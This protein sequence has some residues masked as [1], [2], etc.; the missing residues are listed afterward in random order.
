[1]LRLES[2]PH[3]YKLKTEISAFKMNSRQ[4]KKTIQDL[5][6]LVK[7]LKSE[8]SKLR[9]YKGKPE[10]R[11]DPNIEAK[12]KIFQGKISDLESNNDTLKG[13]LTKI[14]RYMK[15]AGIDLD[16]LKHA[17]ETGELR[18][19]NSKIKIVSDKCNCKSKV[20]SCQPNDTP[21]QLKQFKLK[22]IS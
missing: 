2:D 6:D 22:S 14:M 18:C 9:F 20:C 17:V 21:K 1:M 4:D 7:D 19:T 10:K 15:F 5:E 13:K 16:D 12:I 3:A 8:I 11:Q